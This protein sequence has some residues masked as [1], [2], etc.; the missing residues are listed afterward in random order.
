MWK[1]ATNGPTNASA[2][3]CIRFG[4][5]FVGKGLVHHDSKYYIHENDQVYSRA[6]LSR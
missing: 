3:R 2:V 1:T 5:S 4:R 6:V